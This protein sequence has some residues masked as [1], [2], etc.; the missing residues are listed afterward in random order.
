MKTRYLILAIIF[1][2]VG[3][4]A[5]RQGASLKEAETLIQQGV[6]QRAA[7]QTEAAAESLS[8]AL[9]AIER[10]DQNQAEVQRLKGQIEPR[11]L[12]NSTTPPY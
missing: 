2:V 3:L 9:L 11:W 1:V 12:A 6:E 10:C 4:T 5:C 8:Q 7:K